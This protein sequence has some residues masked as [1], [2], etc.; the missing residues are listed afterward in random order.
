MYFLLLAGAIARG[1]VEQRPMRVGPARSGRRV[2]REAVAL[3]VRRAI[4]VSE[5]ARSNSG[6]ASETSVRISSSSGR[7]SQT[8]SLLIMLF[9]GLWFVA[10]S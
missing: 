6:T 4:R 8:G 1:D 7:S 2:W 3:D 10:G 9:G 5:A